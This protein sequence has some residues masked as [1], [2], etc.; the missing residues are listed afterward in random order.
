MEYYNIFSSSL[1]CSGKCRL[2]AVIFKVG[3]EICD[4]LLY[5]ES[6]RLPCKRKTA[7]VT[8][9]SEN[10]L[11]IT[12]IV[13]VYLHRFL[14]ATEAFLLDPASVLSQV[15]ATVGDKEYKHSPP[16]WEDSSLFS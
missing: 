6:Y 15:F 12:F 13:I 16:P 9:V 11:V 1:I 14:L 10:V 3:K 2:I 8:A 7:L 4:W 5:R